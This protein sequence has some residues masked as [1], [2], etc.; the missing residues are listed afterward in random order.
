MD[1]D[2]FASIVKQ[3]LPTSSQQEK[4]R[5]TPFARE[6]D[7]FPE[8]EPSESSLPDDSPVEPTGIVMVS[9]PETSDDDNN[10]PR[11]DDVDEEFHTASERSES[12]LAGSEEQGP[13]IV[14]VDLDRK[15]DGSV[16]EIVNECCADEERAVDLG[17]DNDNLGSPEPKSPVEVA[18]DLGEENDSLGF[19]ESKSPAEISGGD[20][21]VDGVEEPSNVF[22]SQLKKFSVFDETGVSE[23]LGV[24]DGNIDSDKPKMVEFETDPNE[25]GVTEVSESGF[26]E[27][28]EGL[29]DWLNENTVDVV[30]V[31]PV[32]GHTQHVCENAAKNIV[33][34]DNSGVCENAAKNLDDLAKSGV[35][36]NAAK[37][38][39]DLAK[40]GVCEN[41]TKNVDDLGKSGVRDNA[42]TKNI[43]DLDKSGV[44]ENATKNIEDLDK[45]KYAHSGSVDRCAKGRAGVK[46]ELPFSIRTKEKNMGGVLKS[47]SSNS[48]NDRILNDLFHVLKMV[49]T[50]FDDGYEDSD[51]DFFKTAKRRGLSFPRP[52]WWPPEGFDD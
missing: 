36:E 31:M 43:E 42:A 48:V 9:L 3:C 40:S 12:L 38:I 24:C 18:S 49:V 32:N 34:P 13:V 14:A 2:P 6:S 28:C 50:K 39:E 8:T 29:V 52:R 22:E 30:N 45:F 47:G 20:G 17:K 10:T 23:K 19:R 46:R 35:C 11:K 7:L 16:E 15:I 41:A 4:F 5:N 26:E 21:E 33:D 44:C 1:E 51:S 37:N 25:N 27:N